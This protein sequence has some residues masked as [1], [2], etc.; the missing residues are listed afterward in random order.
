MLLNHT[1][2]YVRVGMELKLVLDDF[3]VVLKQNHYPV[4]SKIRG[5]QNER[6]T[7]EP[8]LSNSIVCERDLTN[9]ME[10]AAILG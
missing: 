6:V 1:V 7:I 9:S 3:S 5:E 2:N 10:S 8:V 4:D